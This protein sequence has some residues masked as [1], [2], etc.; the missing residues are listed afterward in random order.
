[1]STA[2]ISFTE[3]GRIISEK[4]A[5]EISGCKRF[6][7]HKHSDANASDFTELSAL[8]SDIFYKFDALIFISSVGIAVREHIIKSHRPCRRRGR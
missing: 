4:L 1:M 5:S 6:C 8:I 7:F 3:D 2:I